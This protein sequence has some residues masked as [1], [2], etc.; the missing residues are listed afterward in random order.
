MEGTTRGRWQ[1][2]LEK[3]CGRAMSGINWQGRGI[4]GEF[5]WAQ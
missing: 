4:G 3:Q 2:V 1:D 5:L